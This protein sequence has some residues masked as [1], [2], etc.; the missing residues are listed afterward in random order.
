MWKGFSKKFFTKET[1]AYDLAKKDIADVL[2]QFSGHDLRFAWQLFWI[3][4]YEFTDIFF[5]AHCFPGVLAKYGISYRAT[6]NKKR[7]IQK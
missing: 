5:Y 7:I 6:N 3:S 4:A 2:K 1:R